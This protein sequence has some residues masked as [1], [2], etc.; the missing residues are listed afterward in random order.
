[1]TIKNKETKFIKI[2]GILSRGEINLILNNLKTKKSL[3]MNITK[4]INLY[5][6]LISQK[7][8]IL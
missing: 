7:R 1:M 2:A 3:I 5:T 8:E 4:F 6:K